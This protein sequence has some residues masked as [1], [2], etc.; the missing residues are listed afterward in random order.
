MLYVL[1]ER[2]R[3]LKL[4]DSIFRQRSPQLQKNTAKKLKK[5]CRPYPHYFIFQKAFVGYILTIHFW[6]Q[7][8]KIFL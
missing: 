4:F 3:F 5:N 6:R 7:K 8:I 1:E 2:R